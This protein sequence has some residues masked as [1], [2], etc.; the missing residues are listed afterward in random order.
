M[1]WGDA[2]IPEKHTAR[3]LWSKHLCYDVTLLSETD[4]FRY[5]DWLASVINVNVTE[6]TL[7]PVPSGALGLVN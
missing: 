4:P 2:G 6:E 5:S 7:K 3:G 1:F